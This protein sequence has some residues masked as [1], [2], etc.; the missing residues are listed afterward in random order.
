MRNVRYEVWG[1]SEQ[2][3]LPKRV[4][5][6]SPQR[7]EPL[8]AAVG[9][10]EGKHP[11]IP[12]VHRGDYTLRRERTISTLPTV[13]FSLF[14]NTF[15]SSRHTF[16]LVLPL[17]IRLVHHKSV[18][19]IKPRIQCPL[20]SRKPCLCFNWTECKL[21]PLTLIQGRWLRDRGFER[22]ARP[23]QLMY[24]TNYSIYKRHKQGRWRVNDDNSLIAVS[25]NTMNGRTQLW[26]GRS[27]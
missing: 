6:M 11:A 3:L 5:R 24:V 21:T 22:K 15:A 18:N 9:L 12:T 8:L 20:A 23:N 16:H 17:F 19:R 25:K 10:S 13:S 4:K 27:R 14:S 1:G 26:R 2:D 7:Y